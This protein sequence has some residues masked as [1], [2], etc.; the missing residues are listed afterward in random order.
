MAS[1]NFNTEILSSN[2]GEFLQYNLDEVIDKD[3][4]PAFSDYFYGLDGLVPVGFSIDG[5]ILF[6]PP[7]TDFNGLTVRVYDGAKINPVDAIATTNVTVGSPVNAE[8]NTEILSP[9]QEGKELSYNLND[10]IDKNFE[11]PYLYEI[12]GF[13]PD[14][15]GIEGGNTL[16]IPSN[17]EFELVI[18]VS[19]GGEVNVAIATTGVVLEPDPFIEEKNK[20]LENGNVQQKLSVT[21][22]EW[23]NIINR[24]TNEKVDDVVR[25]L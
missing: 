14:G 13:L 15:V 12:S 17:V 16:I 7:F 11:G 25:S 3:F 8:F 22:N 6:V 10:V 5:T 24:G 2:S 20:F 1:A 23:T 21:K 4:P 19:D 9:R 18:V